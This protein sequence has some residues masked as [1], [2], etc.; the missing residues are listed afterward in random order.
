M[1]DIRRTLLGVL[2]IFIS[3]CGSAVLTDVPE[4]AHESAGQGLLTREDVTDLPPGT[5]IGD[6]FDGR[7]YRFVSFTIA[8]CSCRINE[9]SVEDPCDV[10]ELTIP[11]NSV[12]GIRQVDGQIEL[13]D[14]GTQS[15]T[16]P[17]STGPGTIDSDGSFIVGAIGPAF[18]LDT[19]ETVGETFVMWRG[20]ILDAFLFVDFVIRGR[21]FLS[22]EEADCQIAGTQSY[23][24]D[25]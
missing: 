1:E 6:A 24:R 22:D 4:V 7:R 16:A 21:S 8:S 9:T 18:H 3:G 15:P 20:Q 23:A 14:V 2:P 10:F 25:Q 17:V 13:V 12:I 11:D 19:G 5:A